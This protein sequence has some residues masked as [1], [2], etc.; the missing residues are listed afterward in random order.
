MKYLSVLPRIFLINHLQTGSI[1]NTQTYTSLLANPQQ[2]DRETLN[3]L[4]EV[5]D[6]YPFFQSARALWLKGL[7]NEESFRYNDALKLTA[8]H[9]TNRD[10]LFEFI[11]SETFEQHKISRQILINDASINDYEVTISEDVSQ[12]VQQENKE[13]LQNAEA[14]LNPN[15]FEKKEDVLKHMIATSN[16]LTKDLSL[17]HI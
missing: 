12:T 17:I 4:V 14:I 9:T 10:I 5:I 3:Q 6:A 11:T 7:K 15:L 1:L 13:A 8:A 16:A 2:L